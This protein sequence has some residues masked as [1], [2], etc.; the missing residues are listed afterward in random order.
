MNFDIFLELSE[1]QERWTRAS[2]SAVA[3]PIP[4][5]NIVSTKPWIKMLE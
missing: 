3:K 4:H 2:S 1:Y 5:Q